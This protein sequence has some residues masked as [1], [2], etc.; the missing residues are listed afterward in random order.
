[1]LYGVLSGR[2]KKREICARVCARVVKQQFGAA[3]ASSGAADW[4]GGDDA[5]HG[6]EMRGSRAPPYRVHTV[7]LYKGSTDPIISSPHH[8]NMSTCDPQHF[9]TIFMNEATSLYITILL[10]CAI[11]HWS[12]FVILLYLFFFDIFLPKRFLL[13]NKQVKAGWQAW[14]AAPVLA[15]PMQNKRNYFF[16]LPFIWQKM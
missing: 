3:S 9:L 16:C 12:T 11:F 4:P 15:P 13:N 6:A 14:T 8:R 7:P 5:V 2:R 10:R 1:M